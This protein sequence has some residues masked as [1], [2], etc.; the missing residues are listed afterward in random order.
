MGMVSVHP[1]PAEKPY[2]DAAMGVAKQR[3]WSFCP[4]AVGYWRRQVF[5]QAMVPVRWPDH[6][7]DSRRAL[8]PS[9]KQAAVFLRKVRTK[10]REGRGTSCSLES[11]RHLEFLL[12]RSIKSAPKYS[13]AK[14]V[15]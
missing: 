3:T 14:D 11:C 10:T 8:S 13:S 9:R 4:I 2:E 1:S 6:S 7:D 15:T 5:D 12:R